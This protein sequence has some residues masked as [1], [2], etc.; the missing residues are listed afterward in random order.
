MKK[1]LSLALLVL[2]IVSFSPL[3]HADTTGYNNGTALGRGEEINY[4]LGLQAS[5]SGEQF[6]IGLFGAANGYVSQVSSTAAL[7]LSNIAVGIPLTKSVGAVYTLANGTPGQVI[8]F[9]GFGKS[10]S[11]TAVITPATSTGFTTATLGNNGASFVTMYINSTQ[12]WVPVSY[13]NV[14]VS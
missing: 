8:T 5:K 11:D 12:G 4:G 1:F 9:I 13:D 3:A 10:G 6:T 7:P 2:A 14:A